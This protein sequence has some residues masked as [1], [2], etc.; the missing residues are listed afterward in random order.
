M[1]VR[2]IL[3]VTRAADPIVTA[4]LVQGRITVNR[5]AKQLGVYQRRPAN[6]NAI[7]R[8]LADALKGETDADKSAL[9]ELLQAAE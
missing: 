2:K 7:D 8:P 1:Q 9:I 6:D 5:A 4:E 3:A